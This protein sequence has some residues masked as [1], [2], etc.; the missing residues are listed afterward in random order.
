MMNRLMMHGVLVLL[1]TAVGCGWLIPAEN[2]ERVTEVQR[3]T[4][5][6]EYDRQDSTGRREW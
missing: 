2:W 4:W 5:N 1:A 6:R 3:R